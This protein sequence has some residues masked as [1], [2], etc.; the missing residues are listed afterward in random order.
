MSDEAKGRATTIAEATAWRVRLTEAEIETSDAFEAWLAADVRNKAAWDRV[1]G[2]WNLFDDHPTDP[3]LISARHAALDDVRRFGRLREFPW[4]IAAGAAVALITLLGG[5]LFWLE[6]PQDYTTALGERRVVT[7]SDH[8]EIALDSDSEVE[9]RYSD[10]SR[11]LTLVR[12]QARFDVAHDVHRP[13]RVHARD[14]TVI[15]TGTNFDVDTSLPGLLVTLIQGHVK[16]VDASRTIGLD[17]GQQLLVSQGGIQHIG[18][19]D[20]KEITA[21][22][23]GRLIFDDERL[24]TAVARVSR[25][26]TVRVGVVDPRAA[27]LKI[28]GVFKT[29]D[30]GGFVAT[31]TRYL[32]LEASTDGDGQIWLRS[33]T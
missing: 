19:V 30:V 24:A 22:E 7:L 27:E 20:V 26:S 23:T 29:G 16:V 4:R 6:R 3:G 11:D 32:P 15:A 1:T 8:S 31:L 33:R 18:L 12:G 17:P 21:W 13:F 9:V 14:E 2:T 28:N 5:G 10:Y 25:Y